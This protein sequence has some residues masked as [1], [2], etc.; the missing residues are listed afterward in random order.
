MSK[1][2]I[3]ETGWLNMVFEGR[4][5]AYG[6]YQLRAENPKT[7]LR[8]LFSAL[9]LF[10]TL[11]AIP[12]AI[13]Y[14]EPKETA[15]NIKDPV[16]DEPV[17]LVDASAFKEDEP[18][19]DEPKGPE[20]SE[21]LTDQKMAKYVEMVPSEK[22]NITEEPSL[23][24]EFE[25]AQIGSENKEGTHNTDNNLDKTPKNT[26]TGTGGNGGTNSTIEM[27]ATLEAQ[28][29]YPGG[30]TKF[31]KDVG[32]KFNSP[33]IETDSKTLKVLVFFVIEKDGT[34]SN[35]K[36]TRDPGY[37]LGKEAFR[38]LSNMKTKWKPGYKNGQPVRTAYNLPIVVNV[39]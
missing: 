33:T 29:E 31:V 26:E 19:K 21:P 22:Q 12:L 6:A 10:G 25:N 9:G 24:K 4:N 23:N 1:I 8:A 34:L 30:L 2:N 28:P 37:D 5:K 16:I 13:N 7:T 38:V 36:I 39:Q 35:I 11:A 20:I 14:L 27:A 17:I 15:L 18:K 3:F 32:E